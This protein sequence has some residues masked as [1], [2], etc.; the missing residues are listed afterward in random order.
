VANTYLVI[1]VGLTH[2]KAVLFDVDGELIAVASDSYRTTRPRPGWVEQDPEDWWAA[3]V[4]AT[5]QVTAT[6]P[7]LSARIRGIVVTGHM[8][9]LVGLDS[10]GRPVRHALVLGDHRSGVES[11]E[12]ESE[13]GREKLYAIT[14]ALMDP[15]MPA[16][17][18]RYL[19]AHEP[20]AVGRASYFLGCKDFLR[21]RLTGDIGTDPTDACATSLYDIRSGEWSVDLAELAGV[22][23]NQLPPVRDSAVIAGH[24]TTVAAEELRLP[25]GT[26]VAVG[27]GDDVELLGYGWLEP[28]AT[29][30]HV[31]TTGMLMTAAA[32]YAPDPGKALEIYP[33]V[34][35]GRWVLGGSMTSAGS[36]IDWATR[37]LGYRDLSDSA[38]T[39]VQAQHDSSPYFVPHLGGQ[40]FPIHD[41]GAKGS[42]LKLDLTTTR[43]DLMAAVFS[44]VAYSLR[45]L[46]DRLDRVAGR[47]AV[48]H[49]ARA[50]GSVEP[51][52]QHRANVYGRPVVVH[53]C[54]EPT[55]LGSL[56][57]LLT[58]LGIHPDVAT[59]A[60]S[61]GDVGRW[62]V[63]DPQAAQEEETRYAAY[64][65]LPGSGE[66]SDRAFTSDLPAIDAPL[67]SAAAVVGS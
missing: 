16:A 48:I 29:V 13:L 43:A 17:E 23:V 67:A 2:C 55:A 8:H 46:L 58:A 12:I 4:F 64:L 28:Y 52:L 36:A 5:R 39:L 40:R 37:L 60:R 66:A 19:A 42:W 15:S 56:T 14:G 31:G 49:T 27:A 26:P 61:V 10:R 34:V 32:V 57:V 1:D 62:V 21:H 51:W 20:E 30:E 50:A 11:A 44:G 38:S 33:H 35:A 45:Q 7:E 41:P 59:A 25:A 18:L 47:Q 24:L 54:A 53:D 3:A 6:R 65:S 9:A 63:P 22:K